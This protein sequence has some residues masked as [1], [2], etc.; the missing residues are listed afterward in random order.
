M[1][2]E[3]PVQARLFL[4]PTGGGRTIIGGVLN[5]QFFGD[6]LDRIINGRITV[7]TE[8]R[9]RAFVHNDMQALAGKN[10]DRVLT[11]DAFNSADLTR[12]GW[13]KEI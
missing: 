13:H 7:V 2:L 1:N 6:E 4:R 3:L 8:A 12:A 5:G 11:G 9:W 10:I